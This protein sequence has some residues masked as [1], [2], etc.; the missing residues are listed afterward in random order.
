[1]S[2]V[3]EVSPAA[4]TRL[5]ILLTALRGSLGVHQRETGEQLDAIRERLDQAE[6][7]LA[8]PSPGRAPAAPWWP[9][10]SEDEQAA[11]LT[12]LGQWVRN[13]L[14]KWYPGY[15]RSLPECLLN[16]PEAAIELSNLMTEFRRI[17]SPASP[18]L[19]DALALHDRYFPGVLRRISSVTDGCAP[20]MCARVR[21]GD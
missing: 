8:Q 16:H 21:G 15:T 1:M 17:Y 3:P 5:T 12:D 20:G 2:E 9:G 4:V 19:A 7:Q 13:I 18:S 10:M 6:A 14:R 11:A